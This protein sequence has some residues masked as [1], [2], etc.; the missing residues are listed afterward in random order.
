MHHYVQ[1]ADLAK[2]P[3]WELAVILGRYCGDGVIEDFFTGDQIPVLFAVSE[4]FVTG[5]KLVYWT[6]QVDSRLSGF[7][8][9]NV[10]SFMRPRKA[11]L[12]VFQK[13][14]DQKMWVEGPD[15]SW[16]KEEDADDYNE[17]EEEDDSWMQLVPESSTVVE[18]DDDVTWM[19]KILHCSSLSTPSPE[20]FGFDTAEIQQA[21]DHGA[22]FDEFV[23][24]MENDSVMETTYIFNF[25]HYLLE[26]ILDNVVAATDQF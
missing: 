22:I 19:Q 15:D 12:E 17:E 20:F 26:D 6:E 10:L 21:V 2:V 13:M 1:V 18:E 16:M 5:N 23:K 9:Y 4:P 7:S 14:A 11:Q 24:N 25:I 8:N 3:R